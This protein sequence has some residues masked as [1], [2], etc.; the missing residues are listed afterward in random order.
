MMKERA[1]DLLV[2]LIGSSDSLPQLSRH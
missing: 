1:E 2:K